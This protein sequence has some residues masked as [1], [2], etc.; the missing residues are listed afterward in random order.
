MNSRIAGAIYRYEPRLLGFIIYQLMMIFYYD[1][2]KIQHD[3]LI[4]VEIRLFYAFH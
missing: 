1:T 2:S 3:L 4:V